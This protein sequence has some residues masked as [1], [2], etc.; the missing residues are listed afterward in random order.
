M[1]ASSTTVIR[2]TTMSRR[3]GRANR[4]M[5]RVVPRLRRCWATRSEFWIE[6]NMPQLDMPVDGPMSSPPGKSWKRAGNSLPAGY[7]NPGGEDAI[8]NR[9]LLPHAEQLPQPAGLR[10]P[11]GAVLFLV[12]PL[13]RTAQQALD[14]GGR[15][16]IGGQDR[17]AQ[18]VDRRVQ[19]GGRHDR[20]GQPDAVGLVGGDP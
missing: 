8:P 6:R 17:G 11:F 5:R 18:V 7:D 15:G 12:R 19:V 1:Q 14:L 13:A 4:R 10:L 16:R 3:Y 9:S 2:K 20:G